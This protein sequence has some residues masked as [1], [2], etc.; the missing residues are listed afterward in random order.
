MSF[1][2]HDLHTP[3]NKLLRRRHAGSDRKVGPP[4]Q[5]PHDG[6]GVRISLVDETPTDLSSETQGTLNL[7]PSDST[8]SPLCETTVSLPLVDPIPEGRRFAQPL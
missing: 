6:G 3:L 7:T 4:S 2:D 5:H 1:C 8:L